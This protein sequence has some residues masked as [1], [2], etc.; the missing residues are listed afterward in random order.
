MGVLG[1]EEDGGDER[2]R[3]SR[4]EASWK[5]EAVVGF[6]S[7]CRMRCLPVVPEKRTMWLDILFCTGKRRGMRGN[8]P[9]I[10]PL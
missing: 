3:R 5:G 8:V 9:V 1:V 4:D 2:A 7:M 10:A 6:V